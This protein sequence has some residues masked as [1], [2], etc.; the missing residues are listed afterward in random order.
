MGGN[1]MKCSICRGARMADKDRKTCSVCRAR[2]K[3]YDDANR[4]EIT[5]HKRLMRKLGIWES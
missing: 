1:R 3:R 4:K 2:I 5:E